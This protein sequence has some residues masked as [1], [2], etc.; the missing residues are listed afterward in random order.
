MRS[1]RSSPRRSSTRRVGIRCHL[2]RGRSERG[3]SLLELIVALTIFGLLIG[4]AVTVVSTLNQTTS[5]VNTTYSN[6]NEQLWLATNLQRLVRSAVAPAPSFAGK[7][8]VP[9]FTKTTLPSATSMTFTTNL[10]T[11]N[12]PVKVKASCTK[13]PTHTTYC[14]AGS[15]TKAKAS[16]TVTLSRP[17]AGTCP[18]STTSTATCTWGTPQTLFKLPNLMNGTNKQVLFVFG[19]HTSTTAKTVSVH[20]ICAGTMTP[21]KT[22]CTN[23][24]DLT[25]FKTCAAAATGKPTYSSCKVGDI[26]SVTYNVEIN[27]KTS[28]LYPLNGATQAEDDTGIFTLSPTSAL[29]NPTVG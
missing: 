26:D 9:A 29:Y 25:T 6:V 24:H 20:T 7:V 3:F 8:P 10:G 16:L 21:T 13:T 28:T 14:A 2:Y 19:W 12:G 1:A 23:T 4:T 5:R 27:A 15:K 11:K 17:K 18:T 22:N